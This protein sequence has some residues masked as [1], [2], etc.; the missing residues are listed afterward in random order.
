MRRRDPATY[1]TVTRNRHINRT[2]WT[3][4]GTG[5]MTTSIRKLEEDGY[6]E[7]RILTAFPALVPADITAA[8][9]HQR[10]MISSTS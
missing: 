6:D 7:V 9:E 2:T 1:G 5:V 3:I 8:L 4:A 10:A